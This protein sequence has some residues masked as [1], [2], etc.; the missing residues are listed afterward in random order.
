[1]EKR[2]EQIDKRFEQVEKRFEQID[3]RFEQVDRRFGDMIKRHDQ[4]FFWLVGFITTSAGLVIAA[5]R[6]L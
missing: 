5:M 6:F 4:H 3:K 1:M 2:F